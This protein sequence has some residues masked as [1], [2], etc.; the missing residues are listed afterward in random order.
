MKNQKGITLV[1][2]VVTIVVLL[3]LAG[4]TIALVFNDNSSIISNA[5]DASSK[6]TKASIEE[7]VNLAVSEALVAY[8]KEL[9]ASDA[10]NK[11]PQQAFDNSLNGSVSSHT[12]TVTVSDGVATVSGVTCTVGSTTYSVSYT[13]GTGA[14]ATLQQ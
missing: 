9:Y 7:S 12:G 2:L 14:T 1:A 13:S 8:Y 6:T 11:T 10:N 4:V 3:I 5:S